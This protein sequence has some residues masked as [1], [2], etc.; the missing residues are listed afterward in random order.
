MGCFVVAESILWDC[1]VRIAEEGTSS[2]DV[3]KRI[4][5]RKGGDIDTF[6]SHYRGTEPAQDFAHH[7]QLIN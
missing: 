3:S 4:D 2:L 7:S 5:E 1:F 6:I